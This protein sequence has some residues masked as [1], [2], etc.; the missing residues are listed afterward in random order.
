MPD[1]YFSTKFE[2]KTSSQEIISLVMG[3]GFTDTSSQSSA[4]NLPAIESRFY[5]F[6]ND[7]QNSQSLTLES[8][9]RQFSLAYLHA[10][11][12]PGR[13]FTGSKK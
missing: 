4:G 2:S 8:E 11:P 7:K 10:R 5:K 6:I 9:S 3:Q 13:R 1:R 12:A